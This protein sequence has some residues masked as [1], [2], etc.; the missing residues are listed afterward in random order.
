MS[1]SVAD[2][3]SSLR[4]TAPLAV[5]VALA[6]LAGAAVAFLGPTA[7][8]APLGCGTVWLA[9]RYPVVAYSVFLYVGVFKAQASSLNLPIDLTVLFGALVALTCGL[10]TFEGRARTPPVPLAL[11]MAALG[12]AMAVSLVWAPDITYADDKTV[13]FLTLT[14]LAAV[15]PAF[16]IDSQRDLYLLL[17][18]VVGIAGLA[19][20]LLLASGGGEAADRLALGE[21]ADTISTGRLLGA[22]ALVLLFVPG[23]AHWARGLAAVAGGGF[24][25]TALAVGSRGPIVAFGLAA[26]VTAAGQLAVAARRVFPLL[27]GTAVVAIGLG[28]IALPTVAQERIATFSHAPLGTLQADTRASFYEAAIDLTTQYPVRGIG[29]GGYAT[30]GYSTA[31]AET[32]YPHNIFLELSSEL[33]L[34]PPLLL[35]AALIFL[36]L[37]WTR[38]LR[39]RTSRSDALLTNLL[40]GLLVYWTAAAQVSSDINGN[41]AFWGFLGITWLM[42]TAQQQ[43]WPTAP[44]RSLGGVRVPSGT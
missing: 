7:L 43:G 26:L 9:L 15:A 24:L 31:E 1:L 21:S 14:V 27:L 34:L 32:I 19:A 12:L 8:V 30:V 22:G 39:V 41:R 16:L 33:G 10:R 23:D 13:H 36:I 35:A 42:L 28:S 3:P 4:R 2:P 38:F 5:A 17:G 18:A 44:W 29:V 37:K 40:V 11:L 6:M 25:L 20:I